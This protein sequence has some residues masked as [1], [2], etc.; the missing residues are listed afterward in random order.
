MTH[1][2]R[3]S[4]KPLVMLS[5]NTAW[6]VLSRKR[7][8]LAIKDSG[9]DLIALA[10]NDDN[11]RVLESELGI[12]FI[13]LAMKGDG[14]NIRDDIALFFRYLGLYRRY[15]PTV[16]LHINN[17]PNI[18]GSIAASLLG[19][20]SVSNITGLGIVAEKKGFTRFLVMTLYRIAFF[21]KK[22]HVF[23]QNSDDRQYFLDN[24]LVK[25]EKTGLLPGS[26]VDIESF[27]PSAE[28]R[29]PDTG[30]VHFLY[31]SRLV[32]SKG[33][34]EYLDAARAIK[35]LYKN[36]K[37]SIIGELLPN[38]PIFLPVSELET[39]RA[40]GIVEY[41]GVVKNVKPFINAADCIVLP[42]WYRE[43]VPRSLLE[44]AAMGKPLIVADSVGTREPVE[45]GI[46]GY[47]VPPHDG[48]ALREAMIRF[49]ELDND[50]KK[51]MGIESRRIAVTRFSDSFVI[52]M[53][54]ERL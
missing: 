13:P 49:I 11:A 54:L 46:N 40:S 29:Q 24:K 7:L 10:A 38:N 16:A 35:L 5:A 22:A 23:F 51:R 53:Y 12:P 30:A 50:E 15:R 42:S 43:G 27:T 36:A 34:R 45:H 21:S 37:F 33:I 6:N 25:P 3:D 19:I 17:K 47:R 14:T 9:R 20:R 8:L 28:M 18:Y 39:A 32:L 41:H 26:G 1:E 31:N 52:T 2:K 4:A 48:I 44:S